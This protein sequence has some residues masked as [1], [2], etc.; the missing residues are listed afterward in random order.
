MTDD[1]S[2]SPF[3]GLP[4]EFRQF[5]E[6]FTGPGGPLAGGSLPI[7]NIPGLG[8]SPPTGPVD[9]R[10]ARQVAMQLAGDGD[11]SPTDEDRRGWTEALH[12]AELW[13]DATSLPAP[14]DGGRLL[15]AARGDWVDAA[16]AAMRPLVEPVAAAGTDTMADLAE[17]QLEGLDL[18][19]MGL[20]P[21]AEMLGGIDP[22]QLLAPLGAAL[23]GMQAGQVL[24]EL[25]RG[26]LHGT[27]LQLPTGPR[28][29]AL[30][31]V[32]NIEDTFGDWELDPTEV[33]VVLAL[34]EAAVRRVYH[35][36]PWLEGHVHEL[37]ATFAEGTEVDPDQLRRMADDLLLGVD[38]SDPEQMQQAMQAA[39][40]MRVTPTAAQR[41]VLD[42]V[43]GV[44]A[45]VGAWTRHA[46]DVAAADRLPA[47]GRI[48]EVL[49]RRRALRGDGDH[50]LASLL[51]LDLTPD[52]PTL[53]DEFVTVVTDALGDPGLRD[54]IAH[55][56]NLPDL[57]EL[58]D[59]AAWL[60][61]TSGGDV[62]DDPSALLE[63]LGEAPTEAS[64]A[65]R[66]RATRDA[67]GGADDA[68]EDADDLDDADGSPG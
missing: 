32:P 42:R 54:A 21:I 3:D 40:S 29:T 10:L 23:A 1:T 9:W 38:P 65:E 53:G 68:T 60:R 35:A 43:Q 4:D 63:G 19:A 13:L 36:V 5:L 39:A 66:M 58:R 51:G 64:A 2:P 47:R 62:P 30:F 52:D 67:A 50:L 8:G 12:I 24:G 31:V 44:V 17:Q 49:R 55:P 15:V 25:S 59:P 41:R 48:D 22:R 18:G 34:H 27:E 7:L 61:R 11:R 6:Q 56:E 14:P 46:V 37:V 45:L 57:G 26:L 20:G 28:S 33:R 16:L